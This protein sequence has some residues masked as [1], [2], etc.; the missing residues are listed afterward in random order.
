LAIAPTPA[1]M[2][3]PDVLAPEAYFF[4]V[5]HQLLR[6]VHYQAQFEEVFTDVCHFGI[7]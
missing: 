1:D 2:E 3:A 4:Q 5:P 7:S 6:V